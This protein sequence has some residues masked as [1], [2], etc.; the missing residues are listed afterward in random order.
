MNAIQEANTKLGALPKAPSTDPVGEVLHALRTF[1]RDLERRVEGT[2]EEDGLLQTIRPHQEEFRRAIRQ[3][4][5]NF[6]PWEK[7]VSKELPKAAFLASED[8]DNDPSGVEESHAG[9]KI[10]VDEVLKRAQE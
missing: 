4:A 6:V 1:V 7:T 9:Q 10:Y 5:P 8:G 3:T 2:P